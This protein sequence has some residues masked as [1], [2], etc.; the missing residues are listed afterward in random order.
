M[1]ILENNFK[2]ALKYSLLIL[3]YRDRSEKELCFRLIKKGFYET[4]IDDVI[5]YLKEKGLIDD[6][7]L[8]M[9]LKKNVLNRKY[10]S[11][12]NT[13]NYMLLKG[14]SKET[15]NEITTNGD[16][17]YLEG[18]RA[19]IEKKR[20]TIENY[21]DELKKK[22]IWGMLLRKGFSSEEIL[23]ILRSSKVINPNSDIDF[24]Y[25]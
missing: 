7:K 22:K 10:L 9:I 25:H 21:P 16:E 14:I 19:F 17:E 12:K 15:I 4:T 3:K 23:I 20:Q 6:K 5:L 1:K 2:D 11:K 13:I 18:G 8:A 24:C